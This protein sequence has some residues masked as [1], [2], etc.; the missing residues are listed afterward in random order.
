MK[1]KGTGDKEEA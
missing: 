1:V